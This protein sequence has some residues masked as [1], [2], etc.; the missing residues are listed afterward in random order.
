M[1]SISE[2]NHFLSADYAAIYPAETLVDK[3]FG[4]FANPWVPVVSVIL[5]LALSDV[6]C[7]FIRTTFDIKP[8]GMGLQ[9]L[10][11]GH[12]LALAVYSLWTFLNATQIVWAV[13]KDKG[14]YGTV[15]DPSFDLWTARD[16]G[17]WVTHFYISK[18]Y[19]FIDTW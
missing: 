3:V 8:K 19:E 17:F 4:F 1:S 10:T 2:L 9:V 15:C 18:Y 11:V 6:V 7:E 12:S 16:Y 14:F 5:Y 13:M